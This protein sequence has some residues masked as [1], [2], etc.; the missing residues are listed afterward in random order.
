MSPV[1]DPALRA[2]E[3]FHPGAQFDPPGDTRRTPPST[4]VI[5]PPAARTDRSVRQLVGWVCLAT[6]G[7]SLGLALLLPTQVY[8]RLAV[9]PADPQVEQVQLGRGGTALVIDPSSATGVRTVRNV[10]VKL[11]TNVVAAPGGSSDPDSV[12]WQLATQIKVAN[13][14]LLTARVETVSLDRRTARPNNCCGDRLVTD[15]QVP[16]GIPMPHS[17][18][19]SFP[20]NLGKHSYPIWD[21]Q[22]QRARPAA[23]IGEQRLDGFDTYI[24]R[25]DTPF[26]KVGTQSL[27]GR[28]FGTT[29]ASVEADSEYADQ[30]TYWVEP[31][32]GSVIGLREVINQQFRFNGHTVTALSVTLDSPP[33]SPDL[34]DKTRRGAATLP[35]LR[36]RASYLLVPLGLLLLAGWAWTLRPPSSLI[37]D[38][39][40]GR[41]TER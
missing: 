31:A 17:G 28:L 27:P 13:R 6:A 40:A 9:L 14:W 8:P 10:D 16:Q 34:A 37:S 39:G 19:V 11:T 35:W 22:L 4:A 20:F 33:L 5:T 36:G 1:P 26:T 18:F 25:A 32:T 2:P 15:P 12:H 21:V 30:R 41:A 3:S 38:R 7:L 24:L 29:A 23:F